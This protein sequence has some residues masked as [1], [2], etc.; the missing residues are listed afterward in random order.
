MRTKKSLLHRAYRWLRRWQPFYW[1]R[2]HTYNRYHMVDCRNRFYNWG[3]SDVDH[4]M[5][6]ANFEL[7]R[8]FVE[9]EEGLESLAYQ[10]PSFREE[11]E[12]WRGE[13]AALLESAAER[14]HIYDEVRYLWHWWTEE[15][16]HDV[17]PGDEEYEKDTEMLVRLMKVRG[18]LWT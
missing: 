6:Y 5:L 18:S 1:L 14:D 15:R 3:W 9:D 16:P 10:G 17:G 2:C 12:K 4:L 13:K 8:R 7:L 11:A